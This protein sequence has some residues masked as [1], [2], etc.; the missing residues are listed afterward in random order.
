MATIEIDD[1]L[2]DKLYIRQLYEVADTQVGAIMIARAAIIDY[3][4]GGHDHWTDVQDCI[5]VLAAVNRLLQY[6]GKDTVDLASAI[7]EMASDG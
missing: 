4:P 3:P 7:A 6:H 5:E 2:V 1:E